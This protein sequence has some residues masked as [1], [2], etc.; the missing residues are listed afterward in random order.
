MQWH[1]VGEFLVMGG[2]AFYV[3]GSFGVA[4]GCMA[5]EMLLL[6]SRR[7]RITQA[8]KQEAFN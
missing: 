5:I 6:N 3:W 4:F 2:Y 7:Q 1:S 8:F